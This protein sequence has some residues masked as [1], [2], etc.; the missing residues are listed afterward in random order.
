M[1]FYHYFLFFFFKQKTAYEMRISDWSSDVCS[2]DLAA[3]RKRRFRAPADQRRPPAIDA[4][5]R[6]DAASRRTPRDQ[7]VGRRLEF[8]EGVRHAQRLSRRSEERRVGKSVSV[9]VDLGGRRIIKK[10]T[11]APKYKQLI[12]LTQKN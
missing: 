1:F 5:A 6:R 8:F 9:R 12:N 2:S 4:E 7:A 3:R 10:K 11:T